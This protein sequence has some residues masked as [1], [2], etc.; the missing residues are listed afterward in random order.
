MILNRNSL[1]ITLLYIRFA[2]WIS[3]SL[4]GMY[5]VF[6]LEN[7]ILY[8]NAGIK[9]KAT[10]SET[11]R[12]IIIIRAKS[13]KFNRRPSGSKKMIESEATVVSVE[14]SMAMNTRRFPLCLI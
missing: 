14:A 3:L 5:N 1:Q 13:L 11:V 10:N 7:F 9:N 8:I 2:L 4:L 6:R 12:F